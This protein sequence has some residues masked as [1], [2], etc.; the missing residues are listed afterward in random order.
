MTFSGLI[1]NPFPFQ[2]PFIIS[3]FVRLFVPISLSLLPGLAMAQLSVT[4][5]T[6]AVNQLGLL[7]NATVSAAFN[8]ALAS[9]SVNAL[10]VHSMQRGGMRSSRAGSVAANGNAL[11]FTPTY[12]FSPGELISVTATTAAGNTAGLAL[13]RP[14]VWQFGAGVSGPGR[15]YFS[16]GYDPT[17][18]K[19]S[20]A[21]VAGDVDNDG[22]LDMLSA[23]I[24]RRCVDVCFNNGSGI[25]SLAPAN[26][27]PTV[28]PD[29]C[30][31]A[32]GDLDNDG[33]LDI[34]VNT[35]N[36]A[37]MVNNGQGFFAGTANYSI[38]ISNGCGGNI[39]LSDLDG[40]GDL[41]FLGPNAGGGAFIRFNG[42]L[43][44]AAPPR[45]PSR[46]R[47]GG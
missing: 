5:T 21:L 32:I 6:P 41:D 31:L 7:P 25:F 46:A 1:Y 24:S 14:Y 11:V 18:F 17:L 29:P 39:S 23:N 36:I 2:N 35:N 28:R 3:H 43:A 26:P 12:S 42:N 15:G 8:Q 13:S 20:F 10:K 33:D 16:T 44:L 9:S 19:G 34:V 47:L 22:D 30:G 45:N 4:A 27:S 37:L 40:D 38:P